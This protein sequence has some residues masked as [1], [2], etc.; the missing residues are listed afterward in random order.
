MPS[1]NGF[2]RALIIVVD[3]ADQ[4]PVIAAAIEF[5]TRSRGR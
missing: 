3:G 2:V 1:F 5:S 4:G